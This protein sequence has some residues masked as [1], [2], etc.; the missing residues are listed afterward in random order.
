MT[1]LYAKY[2]ELMLGRWDIEKGLQSQKEYQ[3]LDNI[4]MHLSRYMLDNEIPVLSI[5]EVKS[6]FES[7][8][9][10]RNLG[11]DPTYLFNKMIQRCE[12]IVVD[13]VSNTFSFKHRT[14][15][16]FFLPNHMSIRMT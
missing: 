15:P 5:D 4:M 1:E 2:L 9:K 6:Q 14:F 3:A 10:G 11:I 12:M 7:Y 8:L 13:D 16:E